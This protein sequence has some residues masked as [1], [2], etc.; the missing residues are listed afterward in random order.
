MCL[1]EKSLAVAR[2]DPDSSRALLPEMTVLEPFCL[3]NCLK[4]KSTP[5][6]IAETAPASLG[7]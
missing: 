5:L 6:W 3:A 7:S 4:E 1:E 2:Q